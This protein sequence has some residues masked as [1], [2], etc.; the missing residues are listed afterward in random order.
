MDRINTKLS[1]VSDLGAMLANF[2]NEGAR[3]GVLLPRRKYD[4]GDGFSGAYFTYREGECMAQFL[5]GQTI[6]ATAEVLGLS[7]RT[8]EYYLKN[9]KAKCGCRTKSELIHKVAASNF[10]SCYVV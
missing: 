1:G 3:R 4:L 10:V 7:P 2:N 9:M 5:R 8:I 6:K